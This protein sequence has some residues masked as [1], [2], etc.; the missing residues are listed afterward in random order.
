MWN[1]RLEVLARFTA[2]TDCP[3]VFRLE[4]IVSNANY[5]PLQRLATPILDAPPDYWDRARLVLDNVPML[6]TAITTTTTI[7]DEGNNNND[8]TAA[9]AAAAARFVTIAVT[10]KDGRFWSGN[11]G[12]KVADCS[13]RVLGTPE[14]LARVMI[15][16]AASQQQQQQQR[17]RRRR[18]R[19]QQR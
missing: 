5:R 11:F 7:G 16:P 6:R 19:Q 9:A 15:A 12:S 17:R 13:I 10:G 1:C 4:A 3:S 8:A 18:Q 2:R 14:E